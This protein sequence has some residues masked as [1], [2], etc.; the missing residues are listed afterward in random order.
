MTAPVK[1]TPAPKAALKKLAPVKPVPVKPAAGHGK[2][3]PEAV[4]TAKG[5]PKDQNGDLGSALADVK[6]MLKGKGSPEGIPGAAD[7]AAT[8][9]AGSGLGGKEAG[10]LAIQIYAG[11]VQ[12]A[13][14]GHWLIPADLQKAKVEVQLGIRV[15][16]DGTVKDVW[17]DRSSGLAIFDESALR[18]VRAA[19]QFP[20]PPQSKN[21][22]FEF[23]SRFT[24]K[25]ATRNE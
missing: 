4:K 1:S 2:T 22:V 21:G 10:A 3:V 20:P 8:A 13:I 15:G 16:E 19:G 6:K 23:Y 5:K 11:Q 18:A 24:P 25:G 17:V 7:G 14:E 9:H 12:S